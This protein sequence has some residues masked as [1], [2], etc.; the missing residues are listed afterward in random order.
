MNETVCFVFRSDKL[1]FH[2]SWHKLRRGLCVCVCACAGREWP[3]V[4]KNE[5]GALQ[6]IGIRPCPGL[7]MWKLLFNFF[8]L[9]ESLSPSQVALH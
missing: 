5:Q 1:K 7:V 6:L 3:S 4:L 9:A 8:A 2:P